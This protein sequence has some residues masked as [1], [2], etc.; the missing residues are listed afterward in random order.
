MTIVIKKAVPSDAGVLTMSHA[1]TA[2]LARHLAPGGHDLIT[3]AR[4]EA[5]LNVVAPDL[6]LA[7]PAGRYHRAGDA[8]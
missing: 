2:L 6:P 7:R 4:G 5:R 3:A 8:A 1:T